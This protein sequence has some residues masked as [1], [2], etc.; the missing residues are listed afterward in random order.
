VS[1]DKGKRTLMREAIRI[2]MRSP[3]YFRLSLAERKVLVQKFYAQMGESSDSTSSQDRY[4]APPT[5]ASF[6]DFSSLLTADSAL[7]LD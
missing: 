5:A 4:G 1:I 6:E 7:D 3:I 2:L